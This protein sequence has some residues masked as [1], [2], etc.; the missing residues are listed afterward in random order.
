MDS[1]NSLLPLD[2]RDLCRAF[3]DVSVLEGG[4]DITGNGNYVPVGKQKEGCSHRNWLENHR[5]F[6]RQ[7]KV[8]KKVQ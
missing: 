2:S 4:L 8:T 3:A 1:L 7:L 5:P 6:L